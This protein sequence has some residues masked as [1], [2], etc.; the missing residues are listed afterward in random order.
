MGNLSDIGGGYYSASVPT[1]TSDI[2][3][4]VLTVS[5]VKT[6][7][8][9]SSIQ[10]TVTITQVPTTIL[11]LS[12]PLQEGYYGRNVTFLFAYWDSHNNQPIVNGT[13]QFTLESF[14]GT[15]TDLKNGNYSL[16]IDTRLL[17]AGA[18]S[19]D[20]YI[21]MHRSRYDYA[22]T[23][24]KL[25][26]RPIPTAVMGTQTV[27]VPVG[28]D[29]RQLFRF[30]DTLNN[31]L[32]TDATATAVWEFGVASLTNLGNGSYEF[33]AI[34]SGIARL[35]VRNTPYVVHIQF[36]RG[37]YSHAE[38]VLYLTIRKIADSARGCAAAND[39]LCRRHLRGS[40]DLLGCRPQ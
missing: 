33:G 38:F 22:F 1:G 30:N 13:G 25:I 3:D 5:G 21:S 28:D 32:L 31:H 34:E 4:W 39:H 7:Y 9:P 23:V 37:N 24:V 12:S 10:L 8:S 19:H 14:G 35:E 36:S 18:V 16:V 26:V 27:S 2:R 29:Y 40:A 15:V 20:V 11:V 17:T 6:G